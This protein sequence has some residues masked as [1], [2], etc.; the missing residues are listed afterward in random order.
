MVGVPAVVAEVDEQ[1]RGLD[2]ALVENLQRAQRT[3]TESRHFAPAQAATFT[4]ERR[5]DPKCS[6]PLGARLAA[7]PAFAGIEGIC[8]YFDVMT[9]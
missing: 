9:D 6:V 7:G 4:T 3:P 2:G 5:G 8:R 1:T